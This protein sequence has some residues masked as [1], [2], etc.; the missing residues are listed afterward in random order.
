MSK[1]PSA[2][3]RVGI[4]GLG[5]MGRSM[6]WAMDAHPAFQVIGAYDPAPAK[7]RVAKLFAS[8]EELVSDPNVDLVYVASP[9]AHHLAGVALAAAAGK[10]V[11][12]EKPLAASVD[13]ARRCVSVVEQ[14]KIPSAVNFYLAASDA[15]VRMRRFVL[16][17]RL[18]RIESAQLTLR[19]RE[20]PR[21]WQ[22]A[23]GAWLAGPEEGGFTREVA[24]HFLFQM[25]RM[26]GPGRI[27]TSQVWRG[28]SGTETALNARIAYQDVTLEIDAAIAG[29][30]DDHNQ[31]TIC[32]SKARAAIVDWDKLEVQGAEADVPIPATFM[33]DSLALMLSGKPHELAT[34]VEAAEIVALTESLIERGR[35]AV[36]PKQ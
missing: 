10:P 35:A 12:C 32:G 18:G 23:A 7:A 22:R 4:I 36:G 13:E 26:F 29:D 1:R 2:P 6:L 27:I 24:S 33:L 34:F 21:P 19:F 20:W 30:L 9:P 14:A 16:G 11:L 31:L 17:D 25:H 5:V 8:A 28:P 3:H 15:G